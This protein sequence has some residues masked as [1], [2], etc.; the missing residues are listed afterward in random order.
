MNSPAIFLSL[1]TLAVVQ[2]VFEMACCAEVIAD[3]QGDVQIP[4]TILF[5]FLEHL[6]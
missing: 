5:F 6:F 3:R 4:A 1:S 2:L